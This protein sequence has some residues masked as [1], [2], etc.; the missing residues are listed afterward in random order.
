MSR[1]MCGH[2]AN[3]SR[4]AAWCERRDMRDGDLALSGG[5]SQIDT[6][7]VCDRNRSLLIQSQYRALEF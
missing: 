7:K 2:H 1:C 5:R 4:P 3:G 6:T